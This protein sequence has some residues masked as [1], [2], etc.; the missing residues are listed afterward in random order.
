[1]YQVYLSLYSNSPN[2][3]RVVSNTGW[4][5]ALCPIIVLPS[6]HV[7]SVPTIPRTTDVVRIDFDRH[8]LSL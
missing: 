4:P 2:G 5:N 6:L 7:K 3:E 8:R 1:M